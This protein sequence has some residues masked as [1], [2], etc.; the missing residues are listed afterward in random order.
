MNKY[1]C[2]RKV[3]FE[4]NDDRGIIENVIV[5]ESLKDYTLHELC[6]TCGYGRKS[7]A[8]KS[9]D[10]PFETHE[11][12]TCTI[13]RAGNRSPVPPPNYVRD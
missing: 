10:P 1:Q 4:A 8:L 11:I 6:K 2:R 12:K 3:Q 9:R 13:R 7:W 5:L